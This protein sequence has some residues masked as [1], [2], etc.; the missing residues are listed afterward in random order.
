VS[1]GI[2]GCEQAV[3]WSREAAAETVV[4]LAELAGVLEEHHSSA[5]QRSDATAVTREGV[6]HEEGQRNVLEGVVE[7]YRAFGVIVSNATFLVAVDNVSPWTWEP[8]VCA[9]VVFGPR[10][11]HHQKVHRVVGGNLIVHKRRQCNGLNIF[12]IS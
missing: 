10:R 4:L 8:E 9:E 3:V 11:I 1:R 5:R 12:V 7:W 6:G 2:V